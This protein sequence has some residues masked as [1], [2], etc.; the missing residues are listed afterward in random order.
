M[1]M[2]SVSHT[3][4]S[5]NFG[6]CLNFKVNAK[7][8]FYDERFRDSYACLSKFIVNNYDKI[9]FKLNPCNRVKNKSVVSFIFSSFYDIS[10]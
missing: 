8:M 10:C 3:Y 5:S 9:V 2:K 7:Q 1:L 6:H 4:I